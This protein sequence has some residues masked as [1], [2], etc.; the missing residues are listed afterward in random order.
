M[1]SGFLLLL[2]CP[3]LSWAVDPVRAE[4]GKESAWTGEAVPLIITLYSPGPFSGTAAFDLPK[5]PLTAFVKTGNPVVASEKI[6]GE[7]YFTQ[8][9]QFSLYTQSVGQLTIPSFPVRFAGKKT[10]TSAPEPVEGST[11]ELRFE[12][13]APARY[14]IHGRRDRRNNHGSAAEL[15]AGVIRGVAGG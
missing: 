14:R 3:S 5:V 8:Q 9:H 15:E 10:F 1:K 7:T 6:D 4:V 13:K 11:P 12:S 2:L